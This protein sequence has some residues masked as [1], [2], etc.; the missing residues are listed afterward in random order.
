MTDFAQEND[1]ISLRTFSPALRQ[2]T[3]KCF[4]FAASADKHDEKRILCEKTI[5]HVREKKN[6]LAWNESRQHDKRNGRWIEQIT[7][8]H[9]E[10]VVERV[11]VEAR[12]VDGIRNHVEVGWFC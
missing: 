7:K 8:M 11:L 10:R 6:T 2:G 1:S 5:D 9:C 3:K 4:L 12:C